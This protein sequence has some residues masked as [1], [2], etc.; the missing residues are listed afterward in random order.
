MAHILW[1]PHII[2]DRSIQRSFKIDISNRTKIILRVGMK[3]LF[4]WQRANEQN[5]PV[6]QIMPTVHVASPDSF[7]QIQLLSLMLNCLISKIQSNPLLPNKHSKI[8]YNFT[9]QSTY[10]IL[11]SRTNS[12]HQF[13]LKILN[14]HFSENLDLTIHR[15]IQF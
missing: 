10:A 2:F 4:K 7:H 1:H 6:L 13:Y 12:S 15:E 5:W 14:D 3:V 11:L 9:Y 8:T